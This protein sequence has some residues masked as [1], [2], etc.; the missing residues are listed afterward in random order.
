MKQKLSGNRQ[1]GLMNNYDGTYTLYTRGVDRITERFDNG[2][3]NF[4]D[5]VDDLLNNED[6]TKNPFVGADDLWSTF[7]DNLES[8]INSSTNGG[9][10]SKQIQKIDRVDWELVKDVLQG[11]KP[12]SDLGCD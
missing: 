3:G 8:Y 11:Q 7:Q 6:F 2:S 4:L 9:T 1:F 10:A 12:I 5:L